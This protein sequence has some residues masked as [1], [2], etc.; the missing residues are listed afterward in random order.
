MGDPAA[1]NELAGALARCCCQRANYQEEALRGG[2]EGWRRGGAERQER[3]QRRSEASAADQERA[4]FQWRPCL[5]DSSKIGIGLRVADRYDVA[6]A[7]DLRECGPQLVRA[8]AEGS[9]RYG[10]GRDAGR[11]KDIGQVGAR[12]A[13]VALPDLCFFERA[14]VDENTAFSRR[15]TGRR[16]GGG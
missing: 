15:A 4:R 9:E 8:G 16:E 2:L 5:G 7:R 11:G 3:R 13:V 10:L 12:V 6:T 1:R 14:A